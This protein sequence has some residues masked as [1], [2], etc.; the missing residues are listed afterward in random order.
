[1]IAEAVMN[2][3][4]HR[5]KRAVSNKTHI[6]LK[7]RLHKPITTRKHINIK[8]GW[9]IANLEVM[10]PNPFYK[11]TN[12]ILVW[13]ALGFDLD[14]EDGEKAEYATI[15]I[16]PENGHKHIYVELT[17]ITS[18]KGLKTIISQHK[19]KVEASIASAL[20]NIENKEFMLI[21]DIIAEEAH[22]ELAKRL[23]ADPATST[24]I[25]HPFRT[26]RSPDK[27]YIIQ[28]KASKSVSLFKLAN[29]LHLN[30]K[31][32]LVKY[33]E[34]LINEYSNS[35]FFKH[36]TIKTSLKEVRQNEYDIPA[37]CEFIVKHFWKKGHRQNLSMIITGMLYRW[38]NRSYIKTLNH[39]KSLIPKDDE[40][41][42]KRFDPIKHIRYRTTY[43]GLP[44]A[45]QYIRANFDSKFDIKVFKIDSNKTKIVEIPTKELKNKKK[46]SQYEY[47]QLTLLCIMGLTQDKR[48][49]KYDAN[50]EEFVITLNSSTEF[51]RKVNNFKNSDHKSQYNTIIRSLNRLAKSGIIHVVKEAYFDKQTWS[52]KQRIIIR[53]P[54]KYFNIIKRSIVWNKSLQHFSI[55]ALNKI[56]KE[57]QAHK[58][59]KERIVN[60][61]ILKCI[62]IYILDSDDPI[63]DSLFVKFDSLINYTLTESWYTKINKL[64]LYN[65]TSNWYMFNLTMK[66]LTN[67]R[68]HNNAYSDSSKSK[69]LFKLWLIQ[70]QLVNIVYETYFEICKE[71]M[72]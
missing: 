6:L 47:D 66:Q 41:Y 16:N 18:Y 52:K 60:D 4:G 8:Q 33:I 37:L 7:D 49:T 3:D 9:R 12:N 68:M 19:S 39:L 28:T 63:L 24:Q 11:E 15:H 64:F 71:N 62:W 26:L 42:K 5:P 55:F 48:Y 54:F 29:D 70:L 20:F 13:N 1:V 22:K 10:T 38:Y 17:P 53:L 27:S 58:N 36:I 46:L 45:I 23:Q 2:R 57:K 61:V 40:E 65:G 72:L 31:K 51:V 59:F 67:S 44:T 14:K 69:L 21:S 56:L 35:K 43:Y 30:K 34:T 25:N 32:L 50:N